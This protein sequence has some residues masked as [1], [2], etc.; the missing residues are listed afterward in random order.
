MQLLP[1]KTH[2]AILPCRLLWI[3]CGNIL[4]FTWLQDKH[5]LPRSHTHRK[6]PILSSLTAATGIISCSSLLYL[7]TCM[8]QTLKK[9]KRHF[10]QAKIRLPQAK[11]YSLVCSD[12]LTGPEKYLNFHISLCLLTLFPS[13]Q[14][15]AS[16]DCR[17]ISTWYQLR[18]SF[19]CK[20]P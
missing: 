8:L 13:A 7:E 12:S 14:A 11:D 19:F 17:S 1:D 20:W 5:K 10:I 9:K 15:F 16:Y 3:W 6:K 4:L 2:T 18:V